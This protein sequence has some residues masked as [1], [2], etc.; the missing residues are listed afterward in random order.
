MSTDEGPKP[1]QDPLSSAS[2]I[3]VVAEVVIP[4]IGGE[5]VPRTMGVV[6]ESRG[7]D[8]LPEEDMGDDSDKTPRRKRQRQKNWTDAEIALL[9]DHM[10]EMMPQM[11]TPGGWK[12]ISQ[13]LCDEAT[14]GTQSGGDF[15]MIRSPDQCQQKWANLRKE[16]AHQR[17]ESM[18][19]GVPVSLKWKDRIEEI[20]RRERTV[21]M[22]EAGVGG[23]SEDPSMGSAVLSLSAPFE[24]VAVGSGGITLDHSG[25]LPGPPAR[26]RRLTGSA[27]DGESLVPEGKRE[28]WEMKKEFMKQNL[29]AWDRITRA[30]ERVAEKW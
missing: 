5:D 14:S 18:T 6:D 16:L 13:R 23:P 24:G 12:R 28:K 22:S 25:S 17:K 9:L 30:I 7:D 26:K 1:L 11:G 21:S 2:S 15:S 10:L 3:S 19:G 4:T 8:G 27:S 20:L 29:V